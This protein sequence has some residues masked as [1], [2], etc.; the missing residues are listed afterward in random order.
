M[1]GNDNILAQIAVAPLVAALQDP[2]PMED[3]KLKAWLW[4]LRR[5]VEENADSTTRS[6]LALKTSVTEPTTL[7][8]TS[9]Y[10]AT[11]DDFFLKA[12]AT[13]APIT[14]TLRPAAEVLHQVLSIKRLNSGANSVTID[15]DGGETI[16]ESANFVL[17][18]Q[19]DSVNIYSDGTEWW[20]F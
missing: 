13:S 2:P 19:Y 18:N 7:I 3:V 8:T 6:L 17:E 11:D 15:G 4:D 14:I 1:P 5:A 9:T 20:V 12:D 10:T 16:E